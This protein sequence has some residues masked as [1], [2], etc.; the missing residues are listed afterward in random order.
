M[1]AQIIPFPTLD[2]S[3][4]PSGQAGEEL[5]RLAQLVCKRANESG[6]LLRIELARHRMLGAFL[7]MEEQLLAKGR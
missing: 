7:S 5:E 6:R 4:W 2:L 1:T 3:K